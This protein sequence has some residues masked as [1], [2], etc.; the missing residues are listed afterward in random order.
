M[1]SPYVVEKRTNAETEE[2]EFIVVDS[3]GRM[4]PSPYGGPFSSKAEAEANCAALIKKLSIEEWIALTNSVRV[5]QIEGTGKILHIAP[6]GQWIRNNGLSITV[7]PPNE[8]DVELKVGEM[9]K[10]NKSGSIEPP[11]REEQSLGMDF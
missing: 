6:D 4:A 10:V 7:Y 2:V 11:K 8:A 9:V 3:S 1:P 5:N